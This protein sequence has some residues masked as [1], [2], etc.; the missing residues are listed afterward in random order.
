[1][2]IRIVALACATAVNG[3]GWEGVIASAT[4]AISV[5]IGSMA[6]ALWLEW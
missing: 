4:A 6:N 3:L 2:T 1:M 5:S